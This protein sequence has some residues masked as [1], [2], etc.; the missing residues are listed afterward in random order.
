MIVFCFFPV[1]ENQKRT[2]SKFRNKCRV[3]FVYERDVCCFIMIVGIY[4]M[5]GNDKHFSML[6]EGRRYRRVYFELP[7]GRSP[8]C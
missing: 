4:E 7:I 2:R 3:L 1:G 5:F 6:F 8:G